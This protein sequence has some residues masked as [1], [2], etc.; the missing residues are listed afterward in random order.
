MRDCFRADR[1]VRLL[2]IGVLT[3]AIAIASHPQAA[4]QISP[5]SDGDVISA[6][7][8]PAGVKRYGALE[9]TWVQSQ[10]GGGKLFQIASPT[11]VNRNNVADGQ[12]P[13]ELR[14]QNIEDLI[15]LQIGRYRERAIARLFDQEGASNEPRAAQVIISRLSN[16]SVLQV[17]DTATSRPLTLATV[18][19]TDTDFYSQTPDAIA[20]QWKKSLEGEIAKAEAMYAPQ[21]YPRKLQQTALIPV[22]LILLTGILAL[23]RCLLSRRQKELQIQYAAEVQA[24]SAAPVSESVEE[25]SGPVSPLHREALGDA[26]SHSLTQLLQQQFSL[27]N[28]IDLYRL[29][30]WLFFWL[31]V[32]TWYLGIYAVTT[33]LP[34]LMQWSHQVLIQPLRLLIIWF[35]ISL[36]IRV[37]NFL[38]QRSINA[39]KEYPHLVFGDARRQV[40]RSQTIAGALQGLTT[41]VLLL[42]GL[43]LTLTQLGLPVSSILTGSALFGLAITFGAQNLVK[44]V[45]NG[46]LILLEDQFAV[47]DVITTHDE[48]G[49]VERLNLR[50]TQLRNGDGELIS[51]PNS[52]IKLVKNKTSSWSRVN[53]GIKVAYSTDLDQAMAVIE[54][55]ATQMSQE[56]EWQ[57]LI[58]DR[59][60]VLG[61]DELGE[62]GITIRLWM[63]TEPKQQWTIGREVRRRL[64]LAF[65]QE[66]ISIPFPQR[67]VWLEN[68]MTLINGREQPATHPE[69]PR[70]ANNAVE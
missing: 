16:L 4:S 67:S 21:T 27:A 42:F 7:L 55:V 15:R 51:V 29:M 68:P 35:L 25:V 47:G 10:L 26:I 64:K 65:D 2:L 58:L 60:Q 9:V 31:I 59:P 50:L 69:S 66:G 56:P 17:T 30:R 34:S 23:C 24:A 43:L 57:S 70:S 52:S 33:Q 6:K 1:W 12:L 13:V 20:Q 37:S 28:R 5:L 39:W 14:A 61:I 3:F 32:L 40:L 18:T 48:S 11:V 38:I 54:T 22:G 53:L 41:C 46:C 45:V 44:D 36:T 19:S 62:D 8:P 63:Q 49:V